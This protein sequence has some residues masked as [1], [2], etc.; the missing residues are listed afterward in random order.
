MGGELHVARWDM[1]TQPCPS[2]TVSRRSTRHREHGWVLRAETATVSNPKDPKRVSPNE[3]ALR[4]FCVLVAGP[5][6]PV[7]ADGT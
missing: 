1:G 3:C 4:L 6:T 2:S 7:G 5:V